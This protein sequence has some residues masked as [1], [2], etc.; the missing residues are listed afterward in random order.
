VARQGRFE[1]GELLGQRPGV[2][3]RRGVDRLT[4]AE[5]VV[6]EISGGLLSEVTRA[7]LARDADV[8]L[9][10]AELEP[11]PLVAWEE[12]DGLVRMVSP[13]APG[14]PLAE[15]I[16]SGPLAVDE[17]VAITRQVV[18][19]LTVVHARG[20]LHRNIRPTNVVLARPGSA[21]LTDFALSPADLLG[22]AARDLP[23]EAIRHLSPEQAGLLR[24]GVDER[25]DLY[26]VGLL[27][28]ECLAG[29]PHYDGREVGELLRQQLNMPPINLRELGVDVPRELEQLV[30]RL[31]QKEPGDRYQTA[32]AVRGDLRAIA[33][34][35]R[36]EG[37]SALVIGRSDKR[38]VLT[39]P[40][41]VG[42]EEEVQRLEQALV[43]ARL[44][45]GGVVLLEG[46]AGAGK[47]SVLDELARRA[48]VR[49]CWV[50]RGEAAGQPGRPPFQ[51]LD[52]VVRDVVGRMASDA[53]LKHQIRER[54]GDLLPVLVQ[55]LPA[56]GDP[57]G[58]GGGGDLSEET[59]KRRTQRALGRFLTLLGTRERTALLLLDDC[60]WA[61]EALLRG[62]S[63]GGGEVHTLVVLAYCPDDLQPGHALGGRHEFPHVVLTP[64]AD[65]QVGELLESMA[66][67]LPPAAVELVARLSGGNPAM[68]A[69]LLWGLVETDSLVPAEAGWELA[70]RDLAEVQSSR[71][72]GVLLA[73]RLGQLPR[74]V[75]H[76]LRAGAVL[77]RSFETAEVVAVG[78]LPEAVTVELLSEARRRHLVWLDPD[79][80]RWHFAHRLLQEQVLDT[81]EDAAELHQRA[82]RYLESQLD[83]R[84]LYQVA[85]HLDAAGRTEEALPHALDAAEDARQRYALDVAEHHYRI[86]ARGA[87]RADRATRR[88]IAL[89]LG[90]VLLARNRHDE[91]REQLLVALTLCDDEVTRA[92]IYAQLG[93]LAYRRGDNRL[94]GETLEEGL[95]VVGHPAPREGWPTIGRLALELGR[96]VLG[97]PPRPG[98]GS[99]G[100]AVGLHTHL[101]IVWWHYRGL[102]PALWSHYFRLNRAVR[103][104]GSPEVGYAYAFQARLLGSLSLF[105]RADRYIALSQEVCDRLEDPWG[106]GHILF[107]QALVFY[108]SARFDEAQAKLEPAVA[109]LEQAGDPWQ[110]LAAEGILGTVHLRKGDLRRAEALGRRLHEEG[111][112]RDQALPASAGL[113]IW[114][115]ASGG[116]IP[117]AL[118]RAERFRAGDDV[119]RRAFVAQAEAVRLLREGEPRQAATVLEQTWQETGRARVR[120]EHV[121]PIP[122]WLLTAWR[123]WAV[124]DSGRRPALLARAERMATRARLLA[125]RFPNHRPHV[126]R[127]CGLLAGAER[128][129]DRALRYLDESIAVSRQQGARY[130]LGQSL[131]ARARLRGSAGL[132][133]AREDDAEASRLLAECGAD[134]ALGEAYETRAPPAGSRVSATFSLADRLDQLLGV[135]HRIVTSLSRE[136]VFEATREAATNLIRGQNSLIIEAVDDAGGFSPQ[137]VSGDGEAVV[138]STLV[139][140]AMTQGTP[141]TTASGVPE[142]ISPA[143]ESIML[144][145]VRSVLVAPF[146]RQRDRR[147]CL[148][149][150]HGQVGGLFGEEERRLAAFITSLAGAALEN[151]E[152]YRRLEVAFEAL[153]RA[154]GELKS[155]Q[156][157]LVQAAKLAALGQLGAGIAHELNQPIQSIQGFAQR[158]LRHGEAPVVRHRD[159]LEII[160]NATHRMAHI[161]Q[162]IRMFAREGKPQRQ[163]LDPV[164]PMRQALELLQ[165]QLEELG[166]QVEWQVRTL[167]RVL[168]DPVQLQQ[169]FLNLIMN[170][171]DALVTLPE[172]VAR[173]L[174]LS[175]SAERDRI[176]LIVADSGPGVPG[177]LSGR[178]FDPFFTTKEPGEGVGLGLSISYGII[179]DHGGELLCE[180]AASGARFSVVLPV[181]ER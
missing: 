44:G 79:G 173:A 8:L 99:E 133:G 164:Q 121:F 174:T 6:K 101:P 148:Y 106:Q 30:K 14:S 153:D 33:R 23:V 136:A 166:V 58:G 112:Q 25:S 161:V 22:N 46:E 9:D 24:Q 151:A 102:L 84:A 72:V 134:F 78:E 92:R 34:G 32:A 21:R 17:A 104:P 4:G 67:A 7:R 71:R 88:Q 117:G 35:L 38:R 149:V 103:H 68:A 126:L 40:V 51:L 56:L 129:V 55:A 31:L 119:L 120:R 1:Q 47:S 66:G 178:I 76:V 81:L 77:G 145:N 93:R 156:A 5:V 73:R 116:R 144:S 152:S 131:L 171:R 125:R 75:L 169:V 157:Q 86:A 10:L 118:T 163:P 110:A 2:C 49:G 123:L 111:V 65:A 181:A 107:M 127:E 100:L 140:Q 50:L 98:G 36:R 146:A 160:V 168:G 137:V 18:E 124:G 180:P 94:A 70:Q 39:E 97:R 95:R 27:L 176:T 143:S 139:Q 162:N 115:K 175:G 63:A 147:Y 132:P 167:P 54:L 52:R 150:T 158:I 48:A 85:H 87:T 41:F 61:D 142:G 69:A 170:A 37:H 108:A 80:H 59:R 128:D 29:R 159:E 172:G 113:D 122:G 57:L 114:S 105:E 130:E 42:R 179:K 12:E 165:R 15:R 64:L 109:L 177:E 141:L 60:Q 20:V 135:G 90:E 91:A 155:T 82:A 138:S 62:L 45:E 53:G 16:V 154:H 26:S 19:A 89:G 28:F 83:G 74:Q 96:H 43:R 11:A 13:Y 3:T